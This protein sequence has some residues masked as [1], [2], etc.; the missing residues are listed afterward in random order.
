MRLSGEPE[1]NDGD[2]EAQADASAQRHC[3]LRPAGE[4]GARLVDR[5]T[6]QIWDDPAATQNRPTFSLAI[7]EPDDR[8]CCGAPATTRLR[9][10]RYGA[11]FLL[12]VAAPTLLRS[13]Q[14]ECKK[15]Q[16]A[17]F[18]GRRTI[19]FTDS[20]QGTARFAAKLQQEAE[21]T[22]TRAV[23]Y[24]QVNAN[25]GNRNAEEEKLRSDIEELRPVADNPMV[26]KIIAEKEKKLEA[27]HRPAPVSF[28]D[29][30]DA[31]A[32]VGDFQSFV[33]DLWNR[34]ARDR[35]GE[36]HEKLAR[37]FLYRETFRR[38]R[39]QNNVETMGLAA[40][41]FPELEETA[42]LDPCQVFVA[43]GLDGDAW[44]SFLRLCVD[45]VFRQN[46]AVAAPK[47]LI[48][49]ASPSRF[50][51]VILLPGAE[52][53]R[54][55]TRHA[56]P[57]SSRNRNHRLL[58]MAAAGLRLAP[59]EPSDRDLLDEVM[60]A[61]W[62]VFRTSGVVQE[63]ENPNEYA[64]DYRKAAFV[65]PERWWVCP[66]TRR[67]FAYAFCGLSPYAFSRSS[68][69]LSTAM[70]AEQPPRPPQISP[71]GFDSKRRSEVEAWLASDPTVTNLRARGLWSDLHDRTLSFQPFLRSVE[72]SAQ[73]HPTTLQDYEK[74]FE[75]GRVNILNCST[76]MEM[77]VDLA[78][79]DVVLNANVPP[80]PA[81]YRQ[82]VGRAGRRDEHKALA[83]TFC[84]DTPIE[85]AV[86]L[87]PQERLLKGAMRPPE[88]RL[89][90]AVIAQRHVNMFL[91]SR[92]IR[93][94]PPAG[95]PAVR[96]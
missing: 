8:S 68:A 42:R 39:V 19:S 20:R 53:D 44:V 6:C 52:P 12:G 63:T 95:R 47:S 18:D 55:K 5:E 96:R 16:G 22:L 30:V 56:W 34:A 24:H 75:A 54:R 59:E 82:R 32:Q 27:I 76:T 7:C 87:D 1:D 46:L 92:F 94:L 78:G 15:D 14:S 26:A 57:S 31:L 64:L 91:L 4:M 80:A 71:V 49:W 43:Q 11:P 17:A 9:P 93:D 23:I 74:A 67:F 66:I 13:A 62:R 29:M 21:R 28:D 25:A 45:F 48:H 58:R 38:P 77:G 86:F 37:M 60:R 2:D 65:R 70:S 90:S 88:V 83:F 35:L 79:V 33:A 81:N 73:V 51:G 84:K 3:L 89:D 36:D 61:A 85:R 10:M 69:S 40:L 50:A 72:H 41:T